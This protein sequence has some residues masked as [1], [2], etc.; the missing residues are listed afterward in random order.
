MEGWRNA[1]REEEDGER[2][3]G[4]EVRRS[5]VARSLRGSKLRVPGHTGCLGTT[6]HQLLSDSML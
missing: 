4:S 1:I 3:P 6:S 2:T 5:E